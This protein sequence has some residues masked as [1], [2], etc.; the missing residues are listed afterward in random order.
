MLMDELIIDNENVVRGKITL[1][2][3]T[4]SKGSSL[5]ISFCEVWFILVKSDENNFLYYA[6]RFIRIKYTSFNMIILNLKIN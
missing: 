5:D 6:L 3:H 1:A 2:N 4:I